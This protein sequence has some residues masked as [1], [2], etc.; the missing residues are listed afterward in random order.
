MSESE[1]ELLLAYRNALDTVAVMRRYQKAAAKNGKPDDV[2]E[3][4]RLELAVD[5]RLSDLGI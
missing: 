1:K 3:A 4:K 2:K 5:M